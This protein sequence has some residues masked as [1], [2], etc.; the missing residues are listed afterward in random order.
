MVVAGVEIDYTE[1]EVALILV[2]VERTKEAGAG[3]FAP[4]L[5]AG[6]LQ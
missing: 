4:A 2:V 6:V 3:L 5:T 1:Q